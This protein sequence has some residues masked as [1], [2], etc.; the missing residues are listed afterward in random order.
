[1][2]KRSTSSTHSNSGRTTRRSPAARG[3]SRS[4]AAYLNQEWFRNFL[5][6]ML[7]VERGGVQLYE[8]ALQ[9]LSHDDLRDKLEQFHQQTERHV[10]LCEEMLNAAGGED[11]MGAAPEAAEHKAE[12]LLT[13]EV[14]EEMSDINNV[15]NLVLAETK[16]HW[17]WEMLSSVMIEIKDQKLKKIVSRAVREVRKQE[18]DHLNWNQKMLTRL[19]TEAAHKPEMEQETEEGDEEKV[20]QRD[21]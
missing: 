9:Q 4:R 3:Q 5:S 20:A 2:K 14:P 10:E 12:G 18:N 6:E 13:A 17:N 16:D 8:K 11:G 1:M 21:Y 19:A 7:A 15:E